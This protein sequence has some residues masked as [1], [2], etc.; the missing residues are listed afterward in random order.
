M[1]KGQGLPVNAIILILLGIIVLVIVIAVIT[2]KTKQAGEGIKE[3]EEADCQK[4][5][6]EPKPIGT[7]GCEVIYGRFKGL[8][9][10]MVCCRVKDDKA[11]QEG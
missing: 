6:G 9:V 10:D 3:V 5:G 7:P 8:G 4:A 11:E 1:K 2:Q